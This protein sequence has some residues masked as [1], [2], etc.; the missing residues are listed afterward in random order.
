MCG[1]PEDPSAREESACGLDYPSAMD[2][3]TCGLD[4]SA[5]CKGRVCVCLGLR[6]TS[7]RRLLQTMFMLITLSV[8]PFA[9]DASLC[10]LESVPSRR[11]VLACGMNGGA[12]CNVHVS[13]FPGLRR[14]L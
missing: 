3:L 9:Q 13:L 8:A 2:V 11:D 5:I 12:I 6:V 1:L 4:G 10:V 7:R 14:H